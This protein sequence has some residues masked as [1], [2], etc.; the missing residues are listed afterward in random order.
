MSRMSA[1]MPFLN[2]TVADAIVPLSV[3]LVAVGTCAVARRII[4]HSFNCIASLPACHD[5]GIVIC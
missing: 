4:L 2:D 5:L 3:T 1:K